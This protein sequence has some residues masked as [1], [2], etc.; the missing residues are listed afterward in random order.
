MFRR[1]K[2]LPYYKFSKGLGTL[3]L[4]IAACIALYQ[5]SGV[6]DK[7]LEIRTAVKE[8][9]KVVGKVNTGVE[10]LEDAVK[11]IADHLKRGITSDA[12]KITQDSSISSAE[13][14]EKLRQLLPDEKSSLKRGDVYLPSKAFAELKKKALT[15]E[16]RAYVAHE[17]IKKFDQRKFLMDNL[18]VW[19]MDRETGSVADFKQR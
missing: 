2:N 15:D 10:N 3:L 4:G 14:V 9:Q 18:K 16:R 13:K 12:D 8:L 11:K 5:T 1:L 17:E 19:G 7:I 6:L